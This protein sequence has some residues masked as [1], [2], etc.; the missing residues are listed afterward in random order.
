M[1]ID[2]EKLA[3]I[4]ANVLNWYPFKYQGSILEV[5]T[6]YKQVTQMLQE[7]CEEVVSIKNIKEK[8]DKTNKKFDYVLL[9]SVEEQ[10]EKLHDI[11]KYAKSKV[12]LDGTILLVTDNKLGLQRSN[13]NRKENGKNYV[14]KK[15]IESI[16][17]NETKFKN[18]KFYY[19]LPNYKIPNVIFT[20]KHLPSRES[21]QRDLTI[22]DENEILTLE[23]RRS[24]IKLVDEEKELFGIFANSYIVEISNKSD[25][26]IELISFGNSRKEKYRMKT[27][28]KKDF[29]E[30]YPVNPKDTN[31]LQEIKTNIEILKKSKINLLDESENDFIRSKVVREVKTCDKV[32]IELAKNKKYDELVE[33][34]KKFFK[35]ISNK[36]EE[37]KEISNTIFEKYNIEINEEQKSKLHFVKNCIYDLIFQN[38]FY[39][40]NEFYFYDQEWREE[41]APYEFIIFRAINYLANSSKYI[42]RNLLYEKMK[43]KEYVKSFEKLEQ[44]LQNEIVDENIWKIHAINHTNIDVMHN[45]YEQI[46]VKKDEEI[47]QL[48][49]EVTKLNS[50]IQLMENSKSWKIT[51]PLRSIY[52]KSKGKD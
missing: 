2:V 15:E 31:H 5:G 12:K 19:P 8:N 20:D 39:L 43:I 1:K 35:E 28:M 46:I 38:A 24:F 23:E 36:L 14:T 44:I 6:L 18:V 7:K 51:K 48:H 4:R 11:I 3:S 13:Y 25:N 34:I 33:K 40:N 50:K 37:N 30:K 42:D 52:K 45:N 49:N 10:E 26:E 41:N 27:I 29:V 16:V 47:Q 32:L 21:I 9:N 22:Y 17:L